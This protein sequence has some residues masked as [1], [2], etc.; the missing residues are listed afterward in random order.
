[1]TCGEVL[2]DAAHGGGKKKTGWL[3]EAGGEV[4]LFLPVL[5]MHPEVLAHGKENKYAA[6]QRKEED[7]MWALEWLKN[8][9]E[10][11]SEFK[12]VISE[13]GFQELLLLKPYDGKEN[14]SKWK[15]VE[16]QDGTL[17]RT[18]PLLSNV[19]IVE[20]GTSVPEFIKEKINSGFGEGDQDAFYVGDLGDVVDKHCRYHKELP[21]VKPFYAVKCNNSKEVI[22][23]LAILGAGFDCASKAEIDQVLSLGVPADDIVYAN[24][25]KQPCYIRHAAKHGVLKMTFDCESE[26]IKVAENHP[27]AEMIIRIVVNDAEAHTSLSKK[28]GAQLHKCED[29]LKLA[30]FLNLAVIG[31][32]FHIG[33]KSRQ[34]KSFDQAIADSRYVFDL[35]KKVGH[36]MRLLDIGGGFPGD[37][38]FQPRFEEFT[39]VIS[40]ALDQYFPSKEGVEIISEPGRYFIGSA[41][42]AALNIIGKKEDYVTDTDGRKVRKLSY[43]LNDGVIGTLWVHELGGLKMKPLKDHQHSQQHFPTRLWGPCC[44]DYD[45]I[46]E[47]VSLPELEMGEWIIFPNKGAYSLSNATT[48]NGFK[49]P[50]VYYTISEDKLKKIQILAP[51]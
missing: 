28:F 11:L 5:L 24:T 46:I 7:R 21:R 38:D 17:N 18:S 50:T 10:S 42:T 44:T 35:G 45:C 32:S 8:I 2:G 39:A 49:I 36:A 29:L 19:T 13:K 30:K 25:C 51:Q 16:K 31:V 47:E 22:Q 1:M 12:D 15:E 27:E 20:D 43:Y 9:P 37:D 41:F 34:T 23:T 26:L 3:A 48:F 33:T 4:K 14:L 6:L 40:E